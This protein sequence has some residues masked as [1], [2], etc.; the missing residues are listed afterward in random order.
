MEEN[1][2]PQLSHYSLRPQLRHDFSPAEESLRDRLAQEL[3]SL[4]SRL[5]Q[6]ALDNLEDL[7]DD[8]AFL[9]KERELREATEQRIRGL[10]GMLAQ[11]NEIL[12]G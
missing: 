9:E 6:Q 4:D 8:E 12:R 5:E 1:F 10:E 3:M 7:N 2:T 11:K